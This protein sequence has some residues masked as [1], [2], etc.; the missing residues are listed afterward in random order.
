[1]IHQFNKILEAK[2]KLDEG[3]LELLKRWNSNVDPLIPLKPE[4]DK[5]FN[6]K[7]QHR[8]YK[9]PDDFTIH[10]FDYRIQL[11]NTYLVK[12]LNGKSSSLLLFLIS[13]KVF[14][15]FRM[16]SSNM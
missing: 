7:N 9:Y 8:L 16:H 1:M 5:L 12:I 2:I 4:L 10:S 6:I 15:L 3:Q 13:V 11:N 14:F